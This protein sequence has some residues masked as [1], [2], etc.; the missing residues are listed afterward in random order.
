MLIGEGVDV[1]FL[2]KQLGHADPSITL[3]VYA[4]LFDAQRHADRFAA[5]LETGFGER[6]AAVLARSEVAGD[7]G[8]AVTSKVVDIEVLRS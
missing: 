2:S 6:L 3:S 1:V 7:A 5:A 8:D 4:H